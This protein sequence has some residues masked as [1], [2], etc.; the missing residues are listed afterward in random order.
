MRQAARLLCVLLVWNLA[1]VA[2]GTGVVT[3]TD[4]D[5]HA[6]VNDGQG[7]QPWFVKFY[8]PWCGHCKQLVPE[9]DKLADLTAG[10][11]NV[12]DVDAT[13]E[14]SIANE[15]NVQGFPTLKLISGKKMYSYEGARKAA[16]M[17]SWAKGGFRKS[18]GERLPKDQGMFDNVFKS[19]QEY[20]KSVMQ[21]VNFIPSLLPL[22][23]IFGFFIGLVVAWMV[24]AASAEDARPRAP[25]VKAVKKV[26]SPADKEED[27]NDTK[28]DKEEDQS[29]TKKDK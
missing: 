6:R 14:K 25:A 12:A 17:A 27:Q 3:L 20:M 18:S 24:G 9:W 13:V 19:F 23:F 1:P 26:S 7:E 4:K 15:F 28:K 22:V 29:D 5:F 11:V 16:D 10:Q 8:A 21:V 2:Q